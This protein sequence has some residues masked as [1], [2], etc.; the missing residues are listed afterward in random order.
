MSPNSPR[1]TAPQLGTPIPNPCLP[2]GET[3]PK[4]HIMNMGVP[5]PHDVNSVFQYKGMWHVMHQANWSDWA[6]LV[7]TDLAHWTRIA[8]ALSPNGDWDGALTIVKLHLKQMGGL[9]AR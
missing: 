8:S 5:A 7:S 6:H 2:G 3:S 9:P 4:Y 1:W